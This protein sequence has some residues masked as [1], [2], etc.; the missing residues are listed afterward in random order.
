MLKI[1]QILNEHFQ[2]GQ[3]VITLCQ[4]GE[5]SPNL[6]TLTDSE[7]FQERRWNR[8]NAIL[9]DGQWMVIMVGHFRRKVQFE[10]I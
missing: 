1:W 4:S 9:S 2:N 5:I 8:F 7:G 6:V 3:S 10:D